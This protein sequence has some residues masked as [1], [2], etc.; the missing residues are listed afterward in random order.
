MINT[1]YQKI[2]EKNILPKE[3]KIDFS[4]DLDCL[5]ENEIIKV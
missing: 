3:E 4:N 1:I 5:Y 2:Y